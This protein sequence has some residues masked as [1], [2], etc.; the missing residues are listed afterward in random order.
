MKHPFMIRVCRMLALL[1]VQLLILNH[2]HLFGYA[3]PLVIGYMIICFETSVSQMQLLWWGFIMGFIY[4]IFSNTM[5]AGMFS[6]TLLAMTKPYI[7]HLYM[8]RDITE[9][10]KPTI[11]TLSLSR[12]I[13]YVLSCMGVLHVSFY[14]LEA[15]TLSDFWLTLG[16]MFGGTILA[17]LIAVCIEYI[18]HNKLQDREQGK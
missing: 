3:T 9:S 17:S 5:G 6:C 7:L 2:L 11:Q 15:F 10:F 14:L 4:D 12:Y 13:W 1:I 8:P 16:A 18:V